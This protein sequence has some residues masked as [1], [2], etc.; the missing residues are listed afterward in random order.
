[1]MMDVRPDV[2]CSRAFMIPR[3]VM[4]SR[5]EVAS[6]KIRIGVS[7]KMM[8]SCT[9]PNRDGFTMSLSGKSHAQG[10]PTEA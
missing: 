7:F 2:A 8:K 6:S 5:L 9:L 10:K 3:S 4:E 1:M